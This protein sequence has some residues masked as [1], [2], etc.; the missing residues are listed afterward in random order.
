MPLSSVTDDELQD[1]TDEK[2]FEL[3]SAVDAEEQ[4]RFERASQQA[5]ASSRIGSLVLRRRRS[6][7]L[8]SAEQA[9]QRRDGAT[10]SEARTEAERALLS[11]ETQLAEVEGSI[12]QLEN[13]DDETFQRY[14]AAHPAPPLRAA[15]VERLFD[16]DLEFE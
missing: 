5:D 7:L 9:R 8:E 4:K 10:G 2:L 11:L 16:L 1:A 14:L 12:S 15:G 6:S 13:R 3:Q